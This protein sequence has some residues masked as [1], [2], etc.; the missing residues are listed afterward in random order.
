MTK[1][2]RNHSG[3]RVRTGA[4]FTMIGMAPAKLVIS[5]AANPPAKPQIPASLRNGAD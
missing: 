2:L 3:Q 4:R 1:P 5:S